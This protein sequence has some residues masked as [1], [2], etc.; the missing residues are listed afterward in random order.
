MPDLPRLYGDLAGWFHLLTA[1]EEYVEEADFYTRTLR[2]LT[3]P[4]P[5]SVLELGCGGGNNASHMKAH[6]ALT[7]SDVSQ[8]MLDVSRS[9]NPECEH[10][11]GDMRSLRLGR[12]FDGVFAHDALGYLTTPEDLARTIQTAWVHC[13]PGGAV[14]FAPDCFRETFKASTEHGGHDAAARGLRYLEWTWDPDPHDQAYVA[15]MVYLLR[16]ESGGVAVQHERH[17]LGL[18]R[19]DDWL[20]AMREVGFRARSLPF[21]H[22]EIEPGTMQVLVGVKPA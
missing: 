9:I 20:A 22:S 14:L 2:S 16:D 17:V 15:D 19:R 10:V 21:E 13:R 7:L 12:S 5:R 1:P 3:T 11:L 18:F 4:A 8:Q 6:F